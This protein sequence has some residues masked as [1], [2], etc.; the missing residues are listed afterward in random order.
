MSTTT[1][2]SIQVRRGG[3]AARLVAEP[4]NL[5]KGRRLYELHAEA[6]TITFAGSVRSLVGMRNRSFRVVFLFADYNSLNVGIVGRRTD[7][8]SNCI[9]APMAGP[10]GPTVRRLKNNATNHNLSLDLSFA[11]ERSA[12]ILR[13]RAL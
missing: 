4:L 8:S 2:Q 6:D 10:Q 7:V 1:S 12:A 13:L 11:L 5:P 3:I 9:S